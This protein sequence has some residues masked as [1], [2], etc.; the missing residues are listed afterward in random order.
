MILF[1]KFKFMNVEWGAGPSEVLKGRRAK[2]P[3]CGSSLDSE[4]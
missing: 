1:L 3:T 4:K 2:E